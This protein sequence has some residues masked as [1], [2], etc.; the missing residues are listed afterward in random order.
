MP[1]PTEHTHN[2][3]MIYTHVCVYVMCMRISLSHLQASLFSLPLSVLPDW[4]ELLELLSGLPSCWGGS[5]RSSRPFLRQMAANSILATGMAADW[6]SL[7]T[8]THTHPC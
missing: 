8:H 2:Q 5:G 7:R 1:L 6:P 3:H 4:L